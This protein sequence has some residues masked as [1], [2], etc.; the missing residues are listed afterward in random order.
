[1]SAF[2]K[3]FIVFFVLFSFCRISETSHAETG[4][5]PSQANRCLTTVARIISSGDQRHAKG[6]LL[7]PGDQVR[8]I[9]GEQ[10][11]VVCHNGKSLSK[12]KEGEVGRLC[13][14][15][16]KR[17][18]RKGRL[19]YLKSRG[20]TDKEGKLSIVQPLGTMIMQLRPNFAWKPVKGSTHYEV[21]LKG[22]N[23][24][25]KQRVSSGHRLNYPKSWPALE[26]GKAYYVTVYAYQNGKIIGSDRAKLN[27]LY[28]EEIS[29]V[30]EAVTAIHQLSLS[31]V[32]AAKELDAVYM[33]YKLLGES[34]GILQSLRDR[35][36]SNYQLNRLLVD[37]YTQVGQPELAPR[38][39]EA[40]LPTSMKLPQK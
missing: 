34:I 33:S 12:G 8:P 3:I 37:R 35:G 16:P 5:T 39:D 29:L 22:P 26:Y 4:E 20:T 10:P 17:L 6:R 13:S 23:G 1:M 30:Y 2:K 11:L 15:G 19:K 28:E 40:Q 27:L 31:P 9:A 14:S 36:Q 21:T 7:C 18:Q 25:W 32:E 24:N 38:A